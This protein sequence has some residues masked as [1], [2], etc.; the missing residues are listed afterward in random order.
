[1]FSKKVDE[2]TRFRYAS[3]SKLW[4]S[5]AI[6]DSVKQKKIHLETPILE[7]LPS[8]PVPKDNRIE[9]ITVQDLLLHRGGLSR[10]GLM[11][12]EMFQSANPFVQIILKNYRKSN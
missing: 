10:K 5:D 9:N 11:G 4:V 6:L 12:D 2:N 1:M 3:V 8:I 7:L